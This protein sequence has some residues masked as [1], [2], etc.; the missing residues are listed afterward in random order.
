MG[1]VI[2]VKLGCAMM[3]HKGHRC[4]CEARFC[5]DRFVFISATHTRGHCDFLMSSFN[6]RIFTWLSVNINQ[7]GIINI[8]S[9]CPKLRHMTMCLKIHFQFD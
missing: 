6:D 1:H 7:T 5:F 2:F 4:G 3:A 8:C 9:L